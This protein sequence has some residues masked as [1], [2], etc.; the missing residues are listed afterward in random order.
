MLHI[1]S[2]SLTKNPRP[3]QLTPCGRPLLPRNAG[4]GRRTATHCDMCPLSSLPVPSDK[5]A[6][7]KIMPKKVGGDSP[8][9]LSSFSVARGQN[10]L[11]RWGDQV[12]CEALCGTLVADRHSPRYLKWQPSRLTQIVL[13]SPT[14]KCSAETINW[15][16]RR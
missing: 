5:D 4:G 10:R 16:S 11:K 8:L 14:L 13:A 6:A 15:P 7:S 2:A 1:S 9:D 12:F 3:P